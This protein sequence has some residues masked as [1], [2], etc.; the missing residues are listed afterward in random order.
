MTKPHQPWFIRRPIPDGVRRVHLIGVAGVGMGS[1]ACM[2]QDA[3]YEVRGSDQNVYPPMSDVLTDRGIPWMEGWSA[4]H[5]D[6]APDLVVVGNVCR[7]DN[8]ESVAAHERG[9]AT[10]SFPQAFGDLFL[11]DRHPIVVAGTHGKTTTTSLTAWLLYACGRD[12]GM[13]VGGVVRN[14]GALYRLGADRSGTPWVVEGDEYDT[15]WFDKGP[16]FLHYR[17][18]TAILNNIEFDH[19]DI[20]DSLDEIIENFDRLMDLMGPDT[21]L[22][23]NADDA[24]VMERAARARGEVRTYGFGEAAALRAVDVRPDAE[25]CTFTFVRDG[26]TLGS[27]RSPMAGRHNV[28]NTLAAFGACM[29]QGVSFEALVEALRGFEGIKKRQE[30]KGEVDGVLV[31]D[32]YAHHPTAIGETLT[33]LAARYPGRRLWA[34]YEPK[35]NTA[36][37]NVHQ[38]AYARA[39]DAAARVVLAHPYV[40]RDA[41]RDDDRLDVERLVADIAS[42]G[43]EAV[44]LPDV[45][46][47]VE[48]IAERAEA[49]D[50]VVFMSSS[51]FGGVHGKLLDALAARVAR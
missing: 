14:F 2:L 47:I 15:A 16:K 26:E 37:R 9:L 49:G 30:E 11:E 8:P 42:K 19:A 32:D 13:M 43:P 34:V 25:G 41:L 1:F 51:G 12:P 45:P 44:Y 28:W 24:L 21:L 50:L 35:S 3:G 33:A 10:V 7:R 20:Y 4:D 23:A 17:P 5:L 46:S 31:V 39:F 36:R 22:L 38:E 48:Y 27:V 6:W 40:K 18:R 29:A